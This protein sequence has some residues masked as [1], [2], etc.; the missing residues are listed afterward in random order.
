MQT[1]DALLTISLPAQPATAPGSVRAG[2]SAID[3]HHSFAMHL[4]R[5]QTLSEDEAG[6]DTDPASGNPEA[7]APAADAAAANS[8]PGDA[9][10][11]TPECAAAPFG[12]DALHE[13]L[14]QLMPQ[15]HTVP[16]MPGVPG[17]PFARRIDLDRRSET[18][19]LD[20]A[21]ALA[22]DAATRKVSTAA[23]STLADVAF[24]NPPAVAG[25]GAAR[26]GPLNPLQSTQAAPTKSGTVAERCEPALANSKPSDSSRPEAGASAR[27]ALAAG[28]ANGSPAAARSNEPSTLDSASAQEPDSVS[29]DQ[30]DPAKPRSATPELPAT[31]KPGQAAPTTPMPIEPIASGRIEPPLASMRAEPMSAGASV[32]ATARACTAASASIAAHA[33]PRPVASAQATVQDVSTTER[34]GVVR[35]AN[36]R[37]DARAAPG[38]EPAADRTVTRPDSQIA[39]VK[40]ESTGSAAPAS[41]AISPA[42]PAPAVAPA[43]LPMPGTTVVEARIETP[44]SSP[45]FRESLA[46]QVSL[47]ARDGVQHAELQLH[48]ADLG[49]ISVQI[50]LEG[51]QA[52]IHFGADSA[53]TRQLVE[54]GLPALAA[55]LRDAGLTLTGGGVSQHAGGQRPGTRMAANSPARGSVDD[56][57]DVPRARTLRVSLGHLDAYA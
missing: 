44:V 38:F 29:A 54:T 56:L 42:P 16:G 30:P 23:A 25:P 6:P 37:G 14:T 4:E 2:A 45:H 50:A 8:T 55:A 13:F 3:D 15:A 51:Q 31:T 12:L 33:V 52:Q 7:A 35:S 46:L 20:A 43:A 11:A 22:A 17:V 24:S 5:Q 1:S 19:G 41:A 18:P 36:R 57:D 34:D 21:H 28:R 49:P 39:P 53:Q 9:E 40:T 27:R 10:P 32:E 48:P 26:H 47:L